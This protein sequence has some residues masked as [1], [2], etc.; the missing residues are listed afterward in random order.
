MADDGGVV[1]IDGGGDHLYWEIDFLAMRA[2]RWTERPSHEWQR[3]QF[4]LRR[5]SGA[6][7]IQ[8]QPAAAWWRFDDDVANELETLWQRFTA[9]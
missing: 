1:R 4:Q 5:S 8:L 2:T 9:N 3:Q 7:E 6:W